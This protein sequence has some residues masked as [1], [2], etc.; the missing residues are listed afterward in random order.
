VK[1]SLKLVVLALLA[2]G[3]SASPLQLRDV[4]PHP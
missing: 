3:D 1:I 2:T 4:A